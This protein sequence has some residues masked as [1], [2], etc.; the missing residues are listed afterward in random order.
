M[1]EALLSTVYREM[2]LNLMA[3]FSEGFLIVLVDS[4]FGR[5]ELS[6]EIPPFYFL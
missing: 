2:L 5:I 1:R 6:E 3:H 4:Y